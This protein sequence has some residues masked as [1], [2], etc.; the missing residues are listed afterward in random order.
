VFKRLLILHIILLAITSCK[1]EDANY[2]NAWAENPTLYPLQKDTVNITDKSGMKQGYWKIDS[3][4]VR[5]EGYYK[6]N[7]KEGV[8]KASGIGHRA[9]ITYTF[10]FKND[11]VVTPELLSK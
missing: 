3:G 11:T 4:A 6:D 10:M 5:I 8:W 7:R 1:N 9:G 2:E